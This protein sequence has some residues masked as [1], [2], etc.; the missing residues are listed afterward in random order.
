MIC[1][2]HVSRVSSAIDYQGHVRALATYLQA[3]LERN[4]ISARDTHESV[5][6]ELSCTICSICI[7]VRTVVYVST[8][9]VLH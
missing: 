1:N 7:V 6:S 5:K 9:K 8:N 2:W 4:Q 3:Y